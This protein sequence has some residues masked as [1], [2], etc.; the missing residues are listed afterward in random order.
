MDDGDPDWEMADSVL[1]G[2]ASLAMSH[3]GGE[4]DAVVGEIQ[5]DIAHVSKV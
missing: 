5:D 3:S 2:H 1:Q 4:F